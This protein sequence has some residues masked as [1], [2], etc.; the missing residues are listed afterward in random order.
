MSDI[1]I[2]SD[3]FSATFVN[4]VDSCIIRIEDAA[5]R[6]VGEKAYEEGLNTLDLCEDLLKADSNSHPEIWVE[7]DKATKRLD[8]A[9]DEFDKAWEEDDD[10]L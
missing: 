3:K 1:I 6:E 5:R 4:L 10:E 2:P 8:K 7:I 9:Y